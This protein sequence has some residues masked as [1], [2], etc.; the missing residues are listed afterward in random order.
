MPG[1]LR[2]AFPDSLAAYS[3]SPAVLH[4]C[5]Q[6]LDEMCYIVGWTLSITRRRLT[7]QL[8][9]ASMPLC[10]AFY[11]A[12]TNTGGPPQDRNMRASGQYWE[13][14]VWSSVSGP[15]LGPF[16]APRSLSPSRPR[17][18]SSSNSGRHLPLGSTSRGSG[19]ASIV[20]I[21][22]MFGSRDPGFWK[23]LLD[24]EILQLLWDMTFEWSAK[25]ICYERACHLRHVL[26][27]SAIVLYG[28]WRMLMD[29][30]GVVCPYTTLVRLHVF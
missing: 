1:H 22:E 17:E 20:V 10:A 6:H 21:Q 18:Q 24:L 15:D 2:L 30:N 29:P 16:I 26:L 25:M 14:V 4:L 23:A 28:N 27:C 3:N 11:L 19:L 5:G 9:C 7:R 12:M 13:T 8:V